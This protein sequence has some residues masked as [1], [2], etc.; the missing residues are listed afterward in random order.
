MRQQDR[1]GR[2]SGMV[3]ILPASSQRMLVQS[4]ISLLQW[5]RMLPWSQRSW[6]RMLP[7]ADMSPL[8]PG[9]DA[10]AATSPCR[11]WHGAGLLWRCW[12]ICSP[13][14]RGIYSQDFTLKNKPPTT[15]KTV[16]YLWMWSPWQG[17]SAHGTPARCQ[18]PSLATIPVPSPL[19]SPQ[20]SFPFQHSPTPLP[21][22]QRAAQTLRPTFGIS[23]LI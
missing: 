18:M 15:V 6:A 20:P 2:D 8:K 5:E 4:C 14:E 10:T 1:A 21:K 9:E 22:S 11:S 7:R 13:S 23:P 17:A 19:L 16:Q 12:R 3:S